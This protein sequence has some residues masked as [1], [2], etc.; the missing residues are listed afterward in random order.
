M[1]ADK[2]LDALS[3][4]SVWFGSSLQPG[5]SLNSPCEIAFNEHTESEQIET[6]LCIKQCR[7]D[8]VLIPGTRPGFLDDSTKLSS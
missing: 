2:T 5:K 7:F 8:P 4:R 1:R 6:F 3:S